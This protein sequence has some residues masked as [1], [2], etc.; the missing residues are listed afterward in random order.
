MRC[1]NAFAARLWTGG[2]DEIFIVGRRLGITAS[3]PDNGEFT[4]IGNKTGS[5]LY[6]VSLSY[7]LI[8]LHGSFRSPLLGWGVSLR[9]KSEAKLGSAVECRV[10]DEWW[11]ECVEFTFRST[12]T[13]RLFQ[14]ESL[15]AIICKKRKTKT[16]KNES[17][18]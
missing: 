17:G 5:L 12:R 3:Q 11:S 2:E 9:G 15:Q 16:T 4:T 6:W 18:N 7:T 8:G 14:D 10:G 13:S 1:D